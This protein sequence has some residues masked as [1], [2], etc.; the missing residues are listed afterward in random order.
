MNKNLINIVLI[1]AFLFV[2]AYLIRFLYNRYHIEES[3]KDIEEYL[4]YINS[5]RKPAIALSKSEDNRFSK[6]GGLPKMPHDIEWPTWKNA[7]LAFLCQLDLSEIPKECSNIGLPAEGILYFFYD[8][9]QRTWGFDPNDKGS[10]KVIY[11][12]SLADACIL[13]EPPIGL[14]KDYI[15]KEKFVTFSLIQTYPS[16]QDERI[17]SLRIAENSFDEYLDLCSSVFKG[18]PFHQIFGYPA[19]VQGNNMDLE[20]QLVSNGL[21]CGNK[22]GYTN[23]RRK[24]LETGRNEW[25]MLLQLDTDNEAA[26]MWGD[27][28]RLYFWI[29]KSDLETQSFENCWMILQCG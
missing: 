2:A 24:E 7:P 11:S 5:L 14:K 6:I 21:Y 27:V 15:Y 26:M 25:I 29:K 16:W 9:E 8:Q 23:K 18:E 28:G 22:S 17:Y 12:N 13:R 3:S 20:C 1:V 19:P 10:W 4:D